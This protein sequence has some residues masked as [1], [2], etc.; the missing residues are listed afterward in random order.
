MGNAYVVGAMALALTSLYYLLSGN[1]KKK[2]KLN[3]LTPQSAFFYMIDATLTNHVNAMLILD[4]NRSK[5][6]FV[7]QIRKKTRSYLQFRSRLRT[8]WFGWPYYEEIKDDNIL[9]TY[10]THHELDETL[11]LTRIRLLLEE[12]INTP[13]DPRKQLYKFTLYNFNDGKS[14]MLFRMHHCILDGMSSADILLHICEVDEKSLGELKKKS[15]EEQFLNKQG[16]FKG[17]NLITNSFGFIWS[18][19]RIASMRA[20]GEHSL[21]ASSNAYGNQRY[22]YSSIKETIPLSKIKD[23]CK[24]HTTEQLKITINDVVMSSLSGALRRYILKNGSEREK[25]KLENGEPYL[26]RNMTAVNTRNIKNV[27]QYIIDNKTSFDESKLVVNMGNLFHEL[28]LHIQDPLARLKQVAHITKSRNYAGEV[29]VTKTSAILMPYMPLPGPLYRWVYSGM[30]DKVSVVTSNVR[31]PPC[32][33]TFLGMPLERI[34]FNVP[35]FYRLGL[36]VGV[37]TY[38]NQLDMGMG[39]YQ[40]LIAD[41]NQVTQYFYEEVNKLIQT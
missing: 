9:D 26:V 34:A 12:E 10:L 7:D 2:D 38:N 41:P 40:D 35:P 21:R 33:L 3:Y 1:N 18:F 32:L 39:T 17:F 37:Y 19:L 36:I 30:V 8:S 14:V 29:M 22:K 20:E 27:A 13:M 28:P 4:G 31:G 24:R 15:A 11:D 6:E 5:K 23:V 16:S 25:N